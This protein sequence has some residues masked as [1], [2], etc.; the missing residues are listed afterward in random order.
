M[1]RRRREG[2]PGWSWDGVEPRAY[3]NG[4]ERH[5]LV[6]AGDGA[7]QVELRYFEIPAGGAS[8]LE[9]HPHEHAVLILHGSGTVLLGEAVQPV[10]SG[11]AVFVASDEQHQFRAGPDGP[12][13]FACAVAARR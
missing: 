12:L 10:G 11:D 9:R 6:G 4:A 2:A 3:A 8:S 5:L 1:I 7:G 13:G